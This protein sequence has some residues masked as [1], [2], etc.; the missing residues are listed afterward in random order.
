MKAREGDL[1]ETI[2]GNI[3]DVKGF[4]HPP[5][6]VIA[7]IRFTPDSSG[8][9]KRG[10]TRYRKVY[11]LRER[12]NLLKK[13]FPQYLV[14]DR[15]FNQWLCEVPVEAVKR[16]YEPSAYLNQLRRKNARNALEKRAL[17]LAELLHTE[18]GV[19]WDSLGISGSLLVGM[20]TS[21]SDIDLVVYGSKSCRKAYNALGSLVRHMKN[22]LRPYSEQALTELFDF[23]SKD[24]MMEFED[25]VRTESRKVLQGKFHGR[26]Y[27]IRCVKSWN[28]VPETYGTVQYRSIGEAKL[29]ATVIDDSEMIFTPC[30]YSIEDTEILHGNRGE[31]PREIVS[32][33]GRFCEQARTGEKV[34]ARGM[35]ENVKTYGSEHFRLI[36]GNKPSDYLILVK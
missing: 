5:G 22:D 1:V 28:E 10:E 35:V 16:H 19:N 34:I 2:D 7:F 4:I 27:Y 18:S 6:K 33:R 30:T 20:H 3:F 12:Y 29:R 15:V 31:S 21:K 13:E 32:F 14:F 17:E 26:D 8:N 24:T 11:A 9:R 25:F 23:R 36:I